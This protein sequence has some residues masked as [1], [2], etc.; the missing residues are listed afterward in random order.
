[1]ISHSLTLSLSLTH[2]VA[3]PL[4]F[5]RPRLKP[6]PPHFLSPPLPKAHRVRP[7]FRPIESNPFNFKPDFFR[8]NA[9]PLRN[10]GARTSGF[11]KNTIVL[12]LSMGWF[13]GRDV[14]WP[15][16]CL[17]HW[18]ASALRNTRGLPWPTGHKNRV[19]EDMLDWLMYMFGF[20]EHNVANQREHL[21][22]LLANVHMR[23]FPK[24]EQKAKLDDRTITE[25]M[26]KLFKNYK[27]WCE[28]LGRK[29]SLWLPSIQQEVQ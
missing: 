24:L 18:V 6:P 27:K 8:L 21:I 17:F 5:L 13:V 23:Q 11:V 26:K 1:M 14:Y 19:D 20:Q 25:A 3:P 15:F 7:D 12:I 22:L 9:N 4:E 28:Y 29:S 10:F 16:F 2:P